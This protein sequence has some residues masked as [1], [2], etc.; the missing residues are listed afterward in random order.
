MYLSYNR[1]LDVILLPSLQKTTLMNM[2]LSSA[3]YALPS[4]RRFLSNF[5]LDH[6]HHHMQGSTQH[7]L[8]NSPFD[9]LRTSIM[10]YGNS[11]S[12]LQ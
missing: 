9:L 6:Q 12:F 10:Q 5:T 1:S 11:I 7:L 8:Y 2:T 4:K 3:L